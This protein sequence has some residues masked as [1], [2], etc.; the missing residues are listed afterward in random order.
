[1]VDSSFF[2]DRYCHT[3]GSCHYRDHHGVD[4]ALCAFLVARL[5][6]QI[7][8]LVKSCF[9]DCCG[10][11][12]YAHLLEYDN[13]IYHSVICTNSMPSVKKTEVYCLWKGELSRCLVGRYPS[14][15]SSDMSKE[16]FQKRPSWT[17]HF[18]HKAGNTLN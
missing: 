10:L 18:R 2:L 11:L 3:M 7:I 15:S 9:R 4:T 14:Q 17:S 16:Q 8:Y 1:M 13:I 6:R 12:A 5:V